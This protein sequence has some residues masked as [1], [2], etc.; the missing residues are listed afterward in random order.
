MSDDF[1]QSSCINAKLFQTDV[2]QSS[3]QKERERER[4]RERREKEMASQCPS[5]I[6]LKVSPPSTCSSS[7]SFPPDNR[8]Y[9]TVQDAIDA[10]PLRNSIRT[11]ILIPPGIYQQPIYIPKTK[12][13]ITFSG[14]CPET[15]VLTWNNTAAR[16]EHHMVRSFNLLVTFSLL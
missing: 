12:N 13:F 15:T 3:A 9:Q 5:R 1:H 10:V 11:T 16:I 8:L 6:V 14:S 4:G 7:L 2:F